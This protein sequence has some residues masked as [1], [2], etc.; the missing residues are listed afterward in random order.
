VSASSTA[1]AESKFTFPDHY[2]FPPFFTLQPVPE[3]RTKQLNLWKD[4]V[5]AYVRHHRNFVIDVA[6]D[7][8]LPLFCNAALNRT[9][10]ADGRR[11]V[12][13]YL[14]DEGYATWVG[15]GATEAASS[16]SDVGGDASSGRVVATWL[17]FDTWASAL[18]AYADDAA[19]LDSVFTIFELVAGNDTKTESFY[20]LDARVVLEACRRLECDGCC[21]I[22]DGSSPAETGVKLYHRDKE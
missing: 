3:T 2:N 15:A 22:M 17:T 6:G 11:A 8:S 14:V 12:L 1:A 7:A 21:T 20:G 16:G 13:A 18:F 19:Q 4:F 10:D 9:L 5:C